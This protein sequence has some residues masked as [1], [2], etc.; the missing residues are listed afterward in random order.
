MG[1]HFG[2]AVTAL[3]PWGRIEQR[4]KKLIQSQEKHEHLQERG[5]S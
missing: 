1:E 3:V 4:F 2:H 5:I